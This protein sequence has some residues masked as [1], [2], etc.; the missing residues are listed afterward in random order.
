MI[1]AVGMSEQIKPKEIGDYKA[2][3]HFYSTQPK[4]LSVNESTGVVKVLKAVGDVTVMIRWPHIDEHNNKVTC[5]KE[6]TV[7]CVAAPTAIRLN[8]R[9]PG[10]A[11]DGAGT[12][13]NPPNNLTTLE[14]VLSEGDDYTFTTTTSDTNKNLTVKIILSKVLYPPR[15]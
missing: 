13:N 1:L 9:I 15:Q 8:K 12:P 11:D 4:N 6:V 3:F 10:E 2:D 7:T 5:E 14:L